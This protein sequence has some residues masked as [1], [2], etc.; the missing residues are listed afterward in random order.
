MTFNSLSRDHATGV[1]SF[2]L[3]TGSYTFNSLSRDHSVAAQPT[4][5][6]PDVTFNS[7]S[8]DHCSCL[9]RRKRMGKIHFQLPLSGS[10]GVIVEQVG[11]SRAEGNFQL[12]LSGSQPRVGK[13]VLKNKDLI[14]STPSLGIT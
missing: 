14:L 12:P 10:R 13:V 6:A 9:D 5:M 4:I 7:L 2:N 11:L 1:A 8:R 3:T